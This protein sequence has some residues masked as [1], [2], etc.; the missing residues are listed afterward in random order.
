MCRE[1]KILKY[2]D[3][4]MI[5]SQQAVW[6]RVF[7]WQ[8]MS[9]II[10]KFAAIS[11][12]EL[13]GSGSESC[14]IWRVWPWRNGFRERQKAK[15]RNVKMVGRRQGQFGIRVLTHS[16]ALIMLLSLAVSILRFSLCTSDSTHNLLSENSVQIH[17]V[18]S[19]GLTR[20]QCVLHCYSLGN[21]V[22]VPLTHTKQEPV[23]EEL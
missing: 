15:A 23:Q 3:Y 16:C 4:L 1:V 14:R 20:P 11:G 6:N 19:Q 5:L 13:R 22:P 10:K 7:R 8:G 12:D 21:S 18:Q 9:L 2:E 17:I